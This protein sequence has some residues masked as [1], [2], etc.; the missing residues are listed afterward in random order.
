MPGN[1]LRRNATSTASDNLIVAPRFVGRKLAFRVRIEI[2]AIAIEGKHDE[3][4][5]I[6]ARRWDA[7]GSQPLDR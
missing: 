5:R 3:E 2:S 7:R 1:V 6:H 4:F